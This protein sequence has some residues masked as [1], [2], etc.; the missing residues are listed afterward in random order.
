MKNKKSW[1]VFRNDVIIIGTNDTLREWHIRKIMHYYIA[2]NPY[3]DCMYLIPQ[4]PVI[5]PKLIASTR[6]HPG[7]IDKMQTLTYVYAPTPDAH[8]SGIKSEANYFIDDYR[9][10][11]CA[12]I[13]LAY[14]F[15][16][17]KLMSFCCDDVYEEKRPSTEQ[18]NNGLWMYPQQKIAHNLIDGN[19]YWLRSGGINIAHH[20]CGPEYNNAIY[21]A[22][23][24][25]VNFFTK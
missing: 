15:G 10:P 23:D 2:N 1:K 14:H 3:P 9:N 7:F 16:V 11:I 19:L 5:F 13:V 8:Y 12:A 17:K 4:N 6:T 24:S 18:L 25:I 21:V 20:C 22:D